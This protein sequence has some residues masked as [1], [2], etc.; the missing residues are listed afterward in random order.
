MRG[1]PQGADNAVAGDNYTYRAADSSGNP[2]V[3]AMVKVDEIGAG[4]TDT[5]GEVTF[6]VPGNN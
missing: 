3:G 4:T 1:F 5:N 2:I 6:V